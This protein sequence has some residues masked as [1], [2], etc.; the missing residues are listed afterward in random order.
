MTFIE[1]YARENKLSPADFQIGR[2][3][4]WR[5]KKLAEYRRE[6]NI[7]DAIGLSNRELED[8]RAWVFGSEADA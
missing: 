1:I 6:F 2:Y 4:E 8:F 3:Q 5:E 7:P